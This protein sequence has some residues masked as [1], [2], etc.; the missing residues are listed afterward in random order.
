MYFGN[1]AFFVL[2]LSRSG[3]A[4][5]RFLTDRGA[6][7]YIYDDLVSYPL[8][9]TIESLTANGA[10]EVSSEDLPDMHEKAD[11]LVLSPGVPID[12][13]VPVSF[14]KN[15]KAVIGETELAARFLHCPVIAVTGTNGKTTTV[16]LIARILQEWGKRAE[17]CGNSGIPMIGFSALSHEEFA[18]AEISS[19]QLETLRSLRPHIAIE[20]NVTEDHLNRHYNMENYVYLKKRLMKNLTE[21][22]YA[23]LNYD[24]AIT[25]SFADD[26]KGKVVFFSTKEKVN[27]GY[28]EDGYLCHNGEKVLAASELFAEGEH[29]VSDA[30]AA[31]TAAK[32]VGVDSETIARALSEFKGVKHRIEDLGEAFGVSYI[33][34][35]KGTNTDAAK[36]AVACMKKPTVLLLGGKDKGEDYKKLFSFLLKSSVK[37]TVLYGE[38][39]F[40][41]V[42]CAMEV[43]YHSVWL[44]PNFSSAMQTAQNVAERGDC[45]LLSP[46]S[47]SFD[48]FASYEERGEE[49]A[50]FVRKRQEEEKLE[51]EA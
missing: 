24:D 46:A 9:K 48:E 25:R 50:R 33:D 14:R 26:T 7:T 11:I 32:L 5:A 28:F 10:I 49:F 27:G 36:N 16:S 38:N 37:A 4:A 12:H 29:N 45:V 3:E 42:K 43:G 34:D 22:E 15:G 44:C 30:L 18:V 35:S 40:R 19:F 31:V 39:R 23:V 1:Q 21:S 17:I 47:A 51:T 20:L 8:K 6:K 2:G 41:L 13:V